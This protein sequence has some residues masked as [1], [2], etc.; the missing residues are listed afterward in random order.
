MAR[1]QFYSALSAETSPALLSKWQG[2]RVEL[3]A[4][5][6]R[7]FAMARAR[8]QDADFEKAE[9][10]GEAAAASYAKA[11]MGRRAMA[12]RRWLDAFIIGRSPAPG[13]R[14]YAGDSRGAWR[15][16]AE[17]RRALVSIAARRLDLARRCLEASAAEPSRREAA[18]LRGLATREAMEGLDLLVEM[19]MRRA[20]A[21]AWRLFRLRRWQAYVA[22]GL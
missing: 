5:A 10:Y 11:G 2:L 21:V 3:L 7:V 22:A 16:W 15:A 20:A 12:V 4:A 1:R 17:K 18:S 14:V 13:G 6:D 8:A 9:A 19:G